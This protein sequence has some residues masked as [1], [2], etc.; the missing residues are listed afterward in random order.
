M[1]EPPHGLIAAIAKLPDIGAI[2]LDASVDG[3]RAAE[4][5]AL[6]LSAGPL[7]ATA[8]GTVDLVQQAAD[9]DVNA[10]A[11]AMTPAPGVS[12][13]SVALEAHVHGPFTR[14]DAAGHLDVAGLAAGGATVAKLAAEVSGNQG[15]AGLHAT[16]EGVRIPGPKP[17]LLAAAAVV[18]QADVRLDVPARPVTFTVSHPLLL[19]K[20]TANTGG[21]VTAHVDL[22]APDL[23]PFAAAGGVDLQGRTQLAVDAAVAGGTTTVKVDGTV[24]VTGGMAPVPALLGDAAR[25]G[26]TV[27][28]A[29]SDITLSRAEVDGSTVSLRASG[30]D[31]AGVLDLAYTA[32]LTKLAVLSPTVDGAVTL[33]GTAK[34]PPDDLAVVAKLAGDVGTEGVKRGPVQVSVNATGLPGRPAGLGGGHR[35]TRGGAAEPGAA[36]RPRRRRHAARHDREGGL[37]EPACRGR[38]DAGE[39]RHPARRQGQP[40]HD[41]AR[42]PARPSS[43]RR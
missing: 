21:D 18:L 14:P 36:C 25:L 13:Q 27:S 16:A 3:P 43:A 22:T 38:R 20:G 28:L 6:T 11:P 23:Q 7:R 31:R 35:D 15:A 10:N 40:A 42:R 33:T 29:G 26:A 12:W 37:E 5:T 8:K 30:S 34:G 41:A 19:A 2:A 17:D 4:S 1:A 32:G 9:L 39:G 24:G